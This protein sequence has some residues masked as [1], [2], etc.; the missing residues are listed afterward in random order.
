MQGECTTSRTYSLQ[1]ACTNKPHSFAREE[2]MKSNAWTESTE[3]NENRRHFVGGSDAR[4][5]MGNNEAALTAINPFNHP[6]R[7]LSTN[8]FQYHPK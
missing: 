5:I 4:T 8:E 7:W 1:T 6:T 3:S 2:D